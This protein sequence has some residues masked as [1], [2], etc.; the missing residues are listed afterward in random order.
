MKDA[1]AP[2]AK[3]EGN[4]DR[5]SG[6]LDFT[7]STADEGVCRSRAEQRTQSDPFVKSLGA[8]EEQMTREELLPDGA[9][10]HA[11]SISF[12]THWRNAKSESQSFRTEIAASICRIRGVAQRMQDLRSD[13]HL[14]SRCRRSA[15]TQMSVRACAAPQVIRRRSMFT[16]RTVSTAERL[17]KTQ[18]CHSCEQPA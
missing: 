2:K 7:D 10:G 16:H 11:D 8:R 18:F 1:N 12:G 15:F 4:R 3:D 5:L 17:R 6:E 14:R 13:E 9:S